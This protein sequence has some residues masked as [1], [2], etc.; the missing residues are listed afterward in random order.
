MTV[1][2]AL[3]IDTLYSTTC[4]LADNELTLFGTTCCTVHSPYRPFDQLYMSLLNLNVTQQLIHGCK[5]SGAY[6]Y[7]YR[8][9]FSLTLPV[10]ACSRHCSAA[11]LSRSMHYRSFENTSVVRHTY[12]L[13][14]HC[15][16]A[17]YYLYIFFCFLGRHCFRQW[18]YPR[19]TS[20]SW[21]SWQRFHKY[22]QHSKLLIRLGNSHKQH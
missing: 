4:H 11:L 21:D 17:T 3:K 9:A 5:S 10:Y 18:M 2:E 15:R 22:L 8:A 20:P 7:S 19:P 14:R 16:R 12:R 6:L 13:H 1:L